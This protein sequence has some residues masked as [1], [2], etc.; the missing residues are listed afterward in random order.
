MQEIKS[1]DIISWAKIHALFGIVIGLVYGVCTAFVFGAAGLANNMTGLEIFG[2]ASIVIFPIV[3][4]IM[5]FICGAIMA[6]LYNVFAAKVGGV[7]VEL[8]QK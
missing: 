7:Q 6:F 2:V 4:A 3:M 1:I 5:G 8:V